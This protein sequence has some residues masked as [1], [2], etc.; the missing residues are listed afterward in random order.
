MDPSPGAWEVLAD[1][2][3]GLGCGSETGVSNACVLP[4]QGRASWVGAGGRL[5][6]GEGETRSD[7][8][9]VEA[10]PGTP[11][12]VCSPLPGTRGWPR[13]TGGAVC[14]AASAL[15]QASG[16]QQNGRALRKGQELSA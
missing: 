8:P 3:A 4:A 6:E 13:V 1:K 5:P 2:G 16:F 12:P 10:D 7:R 15:C 11:S 14:L 9:A